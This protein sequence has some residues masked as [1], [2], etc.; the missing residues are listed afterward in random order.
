MAAPGVHVEGVGVTLGA[1]TELC[2]HPS[3]EDRVR[4]PT[5]NGGHGLTKDSITAQG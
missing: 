2:G 4:L 3:A 1:V 5:T